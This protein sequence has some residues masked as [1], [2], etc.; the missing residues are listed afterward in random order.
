MLASQYG[1]YGY[2]RITALLQRAGWRIHYNTIRPHSSLGYRPAAP[3]AW[4]TST[5]GMEKWK[6]LR[7]PLFSP[8]TAAIC[9]QR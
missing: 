2:R 3:E 5:T 7:A 4:L 9:T 6:P 1:R 8:P